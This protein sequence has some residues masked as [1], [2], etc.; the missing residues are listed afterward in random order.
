[1]LGS[2]D[3]AGQSTSTCGSDSSSAL[4]RSSS[5]RSAAISSCAAASSRA[6]RARVRSSMIAVTT[7]KNDQPEASAPARRSRDGRCCPAQSGQVRAGPAPVPDRRT[8][9]QAGVPRIVPM[10]AIT[11]R[12]NPPCHGR[13]QP[14]LIRIVSGM[15]L[16]LCWRHHH[17]PVPFL[18]LAAR[19]R[20]GRGRARE[21]LDF[22]LKR[23]RAEE[24]RS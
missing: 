15:P 11:A 18:I 24:S 2:S 14:P 13:A 6:A 1:M 17:S 19:G 12:A 22:T 7:A 20:P 4:A 8:R 16:C 3:A 23:N 21:S 10:A 5:P 9:R